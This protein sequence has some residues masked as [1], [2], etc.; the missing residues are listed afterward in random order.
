M[1]YIVY[2]EEI[3]N[4][5]SFTTRMVR[6]TNICILATLEVGGELDNSGGKNG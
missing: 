6:D 1:S 2:S 5:N 4:S 3:Q